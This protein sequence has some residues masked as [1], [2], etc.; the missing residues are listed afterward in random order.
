[1]R[2]SNHSTERNSM[3]RG[4]Q[5]HRAILEA[6]IELL[7]EMGYEA[8]TLDEVARRAR[9]SKMT[10]YRQWRNK[11]ELTRAALD[12]LDAEDNAAAPD[13]GS[14]RGDLVGVMEMLQKKATAPYLAMMD[15]LML[16]VRH[17][18]TL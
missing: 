5:R 10:I 18:K 8:M 11:A 14:L 9:A 16:A 3:A 13:T 12:A 1:M 6:T 17:D 7:Q 2:P 15:S 4:I